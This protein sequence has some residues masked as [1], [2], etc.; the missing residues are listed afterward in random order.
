M[1]YAPSMSGYSSLS[2]WDG[3]SSS[4]SSSSSSG[5]LTPPQALPPY[6]TPEV[7]S[8]T[9]D[10]NWV[11]GA[12]QQ[13]RFREVYLT[14][15]QNFPL[16]EAVEQC[17]RQGTFPVRC[18]PTMHIEP[19]PIFYGY[20]QAFTEYRPDLQDISSSRTGSALYNVAQP[21]GSTQDTR[22][23][24]MACTPPIGGE[25]IRKPTLLQYRLTS[26]TAPPPVGPHYSHPN[27]YGGNTDNGYVYQV[28][29]VGSTRRAHSPNLGQDQS[30]TRPACETRRGFSRQAP[31][32][33]P[34]G[35]YPHAE[36]CYP[37]HDIAPPLKFAQ[38]EL[39]M[40]MAFAP[41]T[42][43]PHPPAVAYPNNNGANTYRGHTQ[44]PYN[45]GSIPPSYSQNIAEER[46]FTGP[47]RSTHSNERGLTRQKVELYPATMAGKRK[48]SDNDDTVVENDHPQ[49]TMEQR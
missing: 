43:A 8:G 11:S 39:Q 37:Y 33:P 45:F 28:D 49:P 2:N 22:E 24:G 26:T 15:Y 47:E 3:E 21:F 1:S 20:S 17:V 4:P 12:E 44:Q 35:A 40:G 32:A 46:P 7:T 42:G 36:P 48:N 18:G 23:L 25:P 10:C 13:A 41:L 9:T 19:T 16:P 14:P 6:V 5:L 38:D 34:T 30:F 29:G 27:T 31:V